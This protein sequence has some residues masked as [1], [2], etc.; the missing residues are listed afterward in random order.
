MSTVTTKAES[1]VKGFHPQAHVLV[2]SPMDDLLSRDQ[3]PAK[4]IIH[5][6]AGKTLKDAVNGG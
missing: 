2:N 3:I 6:V 1:F 4:K 5:F